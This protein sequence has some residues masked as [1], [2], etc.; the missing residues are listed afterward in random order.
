M[1]PGCSNDM[2]R[3]S[4]AVGETIRLAGCALARPVLDEGSGGGSGDDIPGR[5]EVEGGEEQFL[6]AGTVPSL[7]GRSHRAERGGPMSRGVRHWALPLLNPT[8]Y[9]SGR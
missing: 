1:R 7:E 3:Q 8:S 6:A 2:V 5:A 9:D 4:R